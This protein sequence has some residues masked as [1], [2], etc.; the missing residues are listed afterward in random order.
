MNFLGFLLLCLLFVVSWPVALIALLLYPLF[1]LLCLP[2]RL[3]GLA[4]EGVAMF[5]GALVLLPARLLGY[6]G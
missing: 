2:F 6:R 4:V 1:W 3:L 5:L